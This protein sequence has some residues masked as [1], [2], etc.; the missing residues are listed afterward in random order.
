MQEEW[1]EEKYPDRFSLV[2][3]VPQ[4]STDA[5]AP[6]HQ[7]HTVTLLRM[8]SPHSYEGLTGL[9]QLLTLHCPRWHLS[10]G[11]C[12]HMICDETM[13]MCFGRP[14]GVMLANHNLNSLAALFSV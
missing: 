2:G 7:L 4:A 3:A 10:H 9:L 13:A 8:S 12:E 5:G 6:M 1:D 11:A 14:P